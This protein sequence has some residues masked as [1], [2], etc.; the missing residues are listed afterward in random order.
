MKTIVKGALTA[1][2][3]LDAGELAEINRFARRE[4]KEEEEGARQR[5]WKGGFQAWEQHV[6]RPR[7]LPQPTFTWTSTGFKGSVRE[8][9]AEADLSWRRTPNSTWYSCTSL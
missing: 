8:R 2:G 6:Q 3:T 1:S 5:G 9:Q 4:L 7:G